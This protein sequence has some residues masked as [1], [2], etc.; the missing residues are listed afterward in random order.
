[1]EAE[2]ALLPGTCVNAYAKDEESEN[3]DD[4]DTGEP[5]FNFT[6][7]GDREEVE[8]RD[9]SPEYSDKNTNVEI[10]CPVLNNETAGSQLNSECDCPGEP[11]R[12]LVMVKHEQRT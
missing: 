10:W 2:V 3:C 6:V 9:D 12:G 7:E 8:G 5:K 11:C 4:F 1:M